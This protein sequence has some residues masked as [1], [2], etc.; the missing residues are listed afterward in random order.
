MLTTAGHTE[1]RTEKG[2]YIMTEQNE[3]PDVAVDD[4]A[5]DTE[6]HFRKTAPDDEATDDAEGHFRRT[7]PDDEATDDTE[8]HLRRT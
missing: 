6:G 2:R 5:D 1:H 7:A 4:T 8:G 3:T